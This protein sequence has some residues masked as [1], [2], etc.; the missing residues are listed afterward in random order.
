M[1]IGIGV[2]TVF[3]SLLA[4]HVIKA[5]KWA[6]KT[7]VFRKPNDS[8]K[9][10]NYNDHD[11][12]LVNS[13]FS[14]GTKNSD[15]KNTG[16]RDFPTK[17][18]YENNIKMLQA[19]ELISDR[20]QKVYSLLEREYWNRLNIEL[21]EKLFKIIGTY[22]FEEQ[23]IN[24]SIAFKKRKRLERFEKLKKLM[25]SLTEEQI[26]SNSYLKHVN[27]FMQNSIDDCSEIINMLRQKIDD[28]GVDINTYQIVD[29]E[30]PMNLDRAKLLPSRISDSVGIKYY[31]PSDYKISYVD[32]LDQDHI[33]VYE[34]YNKYVDNLYNLASNIYFL[35]LWNMLSICPEEINHFYFHLSNY[36]DEYKVQVRFYVK[37]RRNSSKQGIQERVIFV[38]KMEDGKLKMLT[39]NDGNIEVIG[40]IIRVGNKSIATIN[41]NSALKN[42][43]IL[44]VNG[45]SFKRVP[46]PEG[47]IT[48][49]LLKSEMVNSSQI[50]SKL[51]TDVV[52]QIGLDKVKKLGVHRTRR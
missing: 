38:R 18:E 6:S 2:G 41:D 1:I 29:I 13:L 50:F 22:G 17:D 12:N 26:N 48:E 11:N 32:I 43:D 9:S 46:K 42:A 52:D 24:K 15:T 20:Y 37:K 49:P 7:S 33:Y 8:L 19:E 35:Q 14:I 40:T 30:L 5:S 25:N 16:T 51:E 28:I 45:N 3:V 34:D 4:V 27:L 36:S 10:E 44:V 39:S 31:R 23:L 47:R 21:E